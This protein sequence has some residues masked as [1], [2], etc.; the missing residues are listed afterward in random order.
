MTSTPLPRTLIFDLDGTL[1]D[2]I[3]DVC[4]S[5][6]EALAEDGRRGLSIAEA[7]SLV[8]FGAHV[9]VEKALELTGAPAPERAAEFTRRFLSIYSANPSRHST[10]FPGVTETL[11]MFAHAGV[12]MGICTNKPVATT[13]PVLE[14][15]GLKNYFATVICGDAVPHRK[16]DGRHIH[17][18]LEKMNADADTCVM[19][20][21][22]ENDI[23]AAIDAGVPSV[24]VTFGY[25]HLPFAELGADELIDH[26]SHLPGAL[27]RIVKARSAA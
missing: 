13:F 18:T 4:A 6:N 10:V 1:I 15:L 19:V 5:V 9:L 23:H 22:S 7:K 2:S 24:C 26:F 25:C 3:P 27:E 12:R 16:P 14:A 20:G 17:Q 11:D 21:D 8:G